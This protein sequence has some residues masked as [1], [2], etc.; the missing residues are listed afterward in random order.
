MSI[1]RRTPKTEPS[2]DWRLDITPGWRQDSDQIIDG[3][4]VTIDKPCWTWNIIREDLRSYGASWL[5]DMGAADTQEEALAIG[6]EK[7]KKAQR[8]HSAKTKLG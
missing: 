5:R 7:M 4:R 8:N 3:V 1:F 6:L 2:P